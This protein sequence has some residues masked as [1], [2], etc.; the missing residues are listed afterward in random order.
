MEQRKRNNSKRSQTKIIPPKRKNTESLSR[1]EVRS[2]NKKKIRRKRKAKRIALLMA[3]AVA[4]ISVGIVLVLSVFFK[5]G[6]VTVKG[7][8][9]Y[10]NKEIILKSGIEVGKNLFRVNE[11]ELNEKLTKSL[12]YIDK[13]TLERQLPDTVVITVTATREVAALQAGSGFVLV[14][15]T[16]KVLDKDSSMLRES[17]A[18]VTGVT[19]KNIAEGERIALNNEN[20]TNDFITLLNGIKESKI[21]LLTEINIT[22]TGEWELRYDDR[23]TIKLGT[24]DNI[25]VKLQRAMAAIEKE[26]EINSYSEGVLDLR[27]EPYAYFSPGEEETTQSPK[28]DENKGKNQVTTDVSEAE[29][30]ESDEGS[31]TQHSENSDE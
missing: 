31:D 29:T 7:D 5:I 3:L 22:K 18:V 12:P 24:V 28:T 11:E 14:D 1:D 9:V 8:K 10:S 6:T 19:P 20:V 16:G 26:N 17:V 23:I 30:T 4:V 2:I 13:V 21:N 15:H 27:T 25:A